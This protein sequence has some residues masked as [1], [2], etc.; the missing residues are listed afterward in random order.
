MFAGII[1]WC[2]ANNVTEIV[3]ITDLRFERILA[4]VGWPLRRLA[5]PRTIGVTNA[6]A[7][8]LEVDIAI[9]EALRPAN[10]RSDLRS[11]SKVA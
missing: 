2:I 4:R 7:G 8:V 1:E 11:I 3:T 10:Y 9:F 6:M 5:E